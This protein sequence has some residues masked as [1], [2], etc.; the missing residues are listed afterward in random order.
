MKVKYYNFDIVFAEIPDETTL[1]LNITNCP[2]RCPGCHSV[3]LQGDVGQVL[4]EE[5]LVGL[6]RCYGQ[7]V[8]CVCFMGGDS[9][10]QE[11][12]RLASVVKRLCPRLKTGWYSGRNALAQ[13]LDPTVFDYIKIGCWNAEAGPL[14]S[15]TTNQHLYHVVGREMRD[16]TSKFWKKQSL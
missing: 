13:G 8:T 12:A 7:A 16:I 2:N 15:P 14:S 1:A 3:H 5:E 9:A 6:I 11:I 10:P 4:D